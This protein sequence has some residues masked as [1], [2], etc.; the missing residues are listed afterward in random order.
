MAE[1]KRP[2]ISVQI[3][4]RDYAPSVQSFIVSADLREPAVTVELAVEDLLKTK[5]SQIRRGMP[6]KIL[7]GYS[8]DAMI[9]LFLGVVRDVDGS[10]N[11]LTIKGID[12]NTILAAKRI[13]ATYQDESAEGNIR[14]VLADTGLTVDAAESGVI[15]DRLP[16]F[17]VTLREAVDTVTAMVRKQTGEAWFDFIRDGVLHWGPPDYDQQPVFS[18]QTGVDVLAFRKSSAGL[19][20]LDTMLVPVRIADVVTVDDQRHFAYIAIYRWRDG[21]RTTLGLERCP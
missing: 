7:W 10:R 20:T 12:Y 21:G 5:G 9:E 4:G 14:A 15:I 2:R 18:F 1:L 13:T 17:N 19:S 16:L 3:D 8:S 11:P 6:L